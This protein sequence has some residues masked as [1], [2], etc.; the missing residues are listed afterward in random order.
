[1]TA[2]AEDKRY[3]AFLLRLWREGE[4]ASW[5]AMLEDPH[6]GERRGFADLNKLFDFIEAQTM[7][8]ARDLGASGDSE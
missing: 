1:M 5:R 4:T 8:A 7:S 3:L 6:T 2:A